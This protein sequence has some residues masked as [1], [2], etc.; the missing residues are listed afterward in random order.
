SAHEFI[1]DIRPIKDQSGINEEDIAKRLMDYGFH[2]P[3]MSWPVPGTMMIE[4]TESESKTELDRFCKAMIS[5]KNEIDDVL[6]GNL[7]PLDN[8]L[9]NAPHTVEHSLSD[10]WKHE[11]SRY[12]ACFPGAWQTEYKYWPSVGRV[13]NAFGD[14]NLVCTCPPVDEYIS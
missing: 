7:D 11:Y 9:K 5:I 8:P 14:R 12:H 3:T 13:D 2:A 10:D 4:P 1:I 6:A